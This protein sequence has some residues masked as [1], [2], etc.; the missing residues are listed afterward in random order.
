MF[1]LENHI[2]IFAKDYYSIYCDFLN[3]YSDF[4]NKF[5]VITQ[6]EIENFKKIMPEIKI[7]ESKIFNRRLKLKEEEEK[8]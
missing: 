4:N 3:V 6:E 2:M 1:Y 7:N 5:Q 8:K